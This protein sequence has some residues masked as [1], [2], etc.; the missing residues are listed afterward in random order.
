MKHYLIQPTWTCQNAC[1]YCWVRTTVLTRPAM[2]RPTE[3]PLEDWVAAIERDKPDLVDIAGGEPLL[4]PWLPDLVDA[5]PETRF[6]LSTNGL[7]EQGIERLCERR[8][9]NLIA[10]NVSYH[11]EAEDRWRGYRARWQRS[12]GL[13]KAAG[14]ALGPNIVDHAANV[15]RAR[16]VLRWLEGLGIRYAVSPY[17]ESANLGHLEQQ[18]L[19][20]QGGVNHLN[21][22]PDGSAWPCLTA[23][24]SPL[25][26]QY[27]LGNWLDGDLDLSRKAQPCHLWCH[28]YYVLAKSHPNGDMWGVQA[29]P[30]QC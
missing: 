2:A 9:P 27:R 3:R 5:C 7:A 1:S 16:P 17:E 28:D 18:G 4:L 19:C 6:G 23:M 21:I 12:V 8:R 15:E 10:V 29:R 14:Y 13:L 25:W 20:C 11:P 24:R 26:E 30:C 22:A